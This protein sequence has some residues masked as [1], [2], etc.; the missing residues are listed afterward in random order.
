MISVIIQIYGIEKY[1]DKCVSSVANQTY[2]NL[3]I[4]LVDDES[5]DNCPQMCERWA[6]R[7]SR[8]KVIHKKNGGLSDA[9]NAGM[10]IAS[11]SYISYIDGDDFIH[12]DMLSALYNVMRRDESDI[13][14]CNVRKF[15]EDESLEDENIS[16]EPESKILDTEQ[17]QRELMLC[18]DIKQHVW[19]RLYKR[20]I[21]DNLFFDYGKYHEDVFWSY[22][23][24]DRAKKVS[25][26]SEQ[27]YYYLQRSG[28]IMGE[29]Y[30]A[31]RLDA[32]DAMSERNEYMKHNRE[33]LYPLSLREYLN[34]C[35]Y[36]YQLVLRDESVDKDKAIRR[37]I[38]SRAKNIDMALAC[39]ETPFKRA[40]WM[41][42]FRR[43]PS[44]TCKLRNAMKIG[45]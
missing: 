13:A 25:L 17:A 11:G 21:T 40:V 6:E 31:K 33:S 3:E 23:A 26:V 20:E 34:A 8:I 41:K 30:S 27:L 38:V 2:K 7:D 43:M 24:F 42:M 18:R 10:K 28:S 9:R 16:A 5:P 4:I 44:L 14:I 45:L 1:L 32:L 29:K 15:F 12:R 39:R 22:K 19:N 36:H 35:I 37:D